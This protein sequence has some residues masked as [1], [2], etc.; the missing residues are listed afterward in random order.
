MQCRRHAANLGQPARECVG[1]GQ[2]AAFK[3]ETAHEDHRFHHAL[4]RRR[5]LA[6]ARGRHG[7]H[8][9]GQQG[10]QAAIGD[11]LRRQ[12]RRAVVHVL[13]AVALALLGF[14]LLRDGVAQAGA[15]EVHRRGGDDGGVHQH[16]RGIEQHVFD[17]QEVVMFVVQHIVLAGGRVVGRHRGHRDQMAVG[18]LRHRL[19]RIQRLAATHRHHHVDAGVRGLRAQLRDQFGRQR[20]RRRFLDPARHGRSGR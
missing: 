20:T 11:Q 19:A 17:G 5:G 6:G 14:E 16:D 9:I 18:R 2:A 13:A 12:Q 4:E 10:A 7:I 1:D 15:E 3:T 8:A